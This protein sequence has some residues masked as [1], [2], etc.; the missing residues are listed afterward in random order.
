M[1]I[2]VT[3]LTVW[4]LCLL[5]TANYEGDWYAAYG[6]YPKS[7]LDFVKGVIAV[8]CRLEDICLYYNPNGIPANGYTIC[9]TDLCNPCNSAPPM[10]KLSFGALV[11]AATAATIACH[12]I[13]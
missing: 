8:L 3:L 10:A 7:D 4:V 5:L 12:A 13:H 1:I 2:L 9:D 6:C 11:V